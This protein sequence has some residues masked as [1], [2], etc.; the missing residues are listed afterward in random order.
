MLD[1]HNDNHAEVEGWNYKQQKIFLRKSVRKS[2]N[3]R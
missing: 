2:I 3:N 1:Y